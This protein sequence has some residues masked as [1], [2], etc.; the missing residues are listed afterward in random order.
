MTWVDVLQSLWSLLP[1]GSQSV[2]NDFEETWK[3]SSSLRRFQMSSSS[4]HYIFTSRWSTIVTIGEV[5]QFGYSIAL[6]KNAT[7]SLFDIFPVETMY[8]S[9][10]EKQGWI[11]K[12][13]TRYERW[14]NIACLFQLSAL[15][16]FI[17]FSLPYTGHSIHA[18]TQERFSS[19]QWRESSL[20]SIHTECIILERILQTDYEKSAY[21]YFVPT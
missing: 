11:Q 12:E 8:C 17:N 3:F 6:K 21:I 7:K 14:A 15:A 9:C 5:L 19:N 18:F 13:F 2:R 16:L 20:Q 10:S 4:N 1:V